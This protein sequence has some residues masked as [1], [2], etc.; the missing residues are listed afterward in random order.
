MVLHVSLSFLTFE[1][2][3]TLLERIKKNGIGRTLQNANQ[4]SGLVVNFVIFFTYTMLF[5]YLNGTNRKSQ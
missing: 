4:T 5:W 3:E 2:I 1:K